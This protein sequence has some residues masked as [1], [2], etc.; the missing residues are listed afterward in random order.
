MIIKKVVRQQK[1]F[2]IKKTLIN[3]FDLDNGKNV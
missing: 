3:T 2:K 1:M